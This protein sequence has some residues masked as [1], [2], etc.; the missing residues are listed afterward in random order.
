MHSCNRW[1]GR[2]LTSAFVAATFAAGL[3]HGVANA[4]P[5]PAS[6]DNYIFCN[7]GMDARDLGGGWPWDRRYVVEVNRNWGNRDAPGKS[8]YYRRPNGTVERLS[9]AYHG[10]FDG[11]ARWGVSTWWAYWNPDWQQD[12]RWS[13]SYICGQRR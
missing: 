12:W 9:L 10:D 8:I 7:I 11:R 1:I 4:A 2:S 3:L 6:L 13:M 5:E